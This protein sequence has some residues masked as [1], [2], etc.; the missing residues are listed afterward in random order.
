MTSVSPATSAMSTPLF[1]QAELRAMFNA[2]AQHGVKVASH[3]YTKSSVH[4]LLTLGAWSIEHAF[5]DSFLEH[6]LGHLPFS[7]QTTWVPTLSV[8]WASRSGAGGQK[9]WETAAA[10]FKQA[11][12]AGVERVATGG[13]T[14]TFPHGDNALEL[15]LMVRLGAPWATVLRWA[16]LGGWECIRSMGWEGPEGK[17]RLERAECLEGGGEDPRVV[18]DNEVPFGAVRK[19]WAADIIALKGDVEKDFENAARKDAVKF[20]MKG[21]RVFKRDGN[22]VPCM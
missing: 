10:S 1:N 7:G 19:G 6:P 12:A 3:S 8:Y 9:R 2:A 11:L 21:G 17:A 5:Y 15:Q 20:V 16:T 13:D 22:E 14:G 4:N 18:G